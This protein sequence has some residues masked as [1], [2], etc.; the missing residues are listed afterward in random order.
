MKA[1]GNFLQDIY[2][3]IFVLFLK[4]SFGQWPE[5]SAANAHTGV[6]GLAIVN[7]L[8]ALIAFFWIQI[9]TGQ[10]IRLQRWI[11][12]VVLTLPFIYNYYFLIIRRQGY[13][14][15]MRFNSFSKE[16]RIVLLSVAVTAILVIAAALYF[17]G[18]S[19]RRV[20]LMR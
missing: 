3:S 5:K 12:A 8:L 11:I 17:V 4:I 13:L 7:G 19:Y 10:R 14:F 18:I 2:L 15:E 1:L 6:I 16:K 9:E 20:F